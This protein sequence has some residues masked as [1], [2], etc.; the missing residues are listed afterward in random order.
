MSQKIDFSASVEPWIQ[1]TPKG[2]KSVFEYSSQWLDFELRDFLATNPNPVVAHV[3]CRLKYTDKRRLE[4]WLKRQ[5]A[6]ED[7]TV[8]QSKRLRSSGSG[9]TWKQHCFLCAGPAAIDE[10]H[11]DRCD[12][13]YVRTLQIYDNTMK[14]A[15]QRNDQ[16][17]L[18]VLGRLQA[19]HDL[20][21]EEAVYHRNCLRLFCSYRPPKLEVTAQQSERRS[22]CCVAG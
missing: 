10:R 13:S 9:F 6:E 18:E 2:I 4:Q 1:L 14:V 22:S 12:T 15:A 5:K 20:V 21:A 16:W 17:A 11:P 3:A 7:I 19:C 8:P